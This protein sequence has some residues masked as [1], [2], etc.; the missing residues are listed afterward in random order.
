MMATNAGIPTAA[1]PEA[2]ACA[3]FKCVALAELGE[4]LGLWVW[5]CEA[6]STARVVVLEVSEEPD[7]LD[8]VD[9]PAPLVSAAAKSTVISTIVW[10]T[11]PD[12]SPL[13]IAQVPTPSVPTRQSMLA[14]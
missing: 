13:N 14:V 7:P 9:V 12:H 10:V 2:R 4:W 8:T 6:P 5:V 11:V 1:N 3:P